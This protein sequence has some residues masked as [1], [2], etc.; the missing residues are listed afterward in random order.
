MYQKQPLASATSRPPETAATNAGRRP[1]ALPSRRESVAFGWRC[2][3]FDGQKTYRPSSDTT[4]G[5][6]VSE[7]I[8]MT[9]TAIASAGPSEPKNPSEASS[10]TR[11]ATMTAAAADA[12]TSPTRC[13]RDHH[14]GPLVVAGAQPFP[15]AEE[16]EQ[17]VVG[18]DAE[19]HDQQD[20]LQILTDVEVE[21]LADRRDQAGSTV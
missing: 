21:Q 8:S 10:S 2:H 13:D 16:Q 7:V 6:S 5:I 12:M 4:A 9:P 15:V 1:T 17:D 18:A 19:Q 3:A 14:R 11:N 20:R